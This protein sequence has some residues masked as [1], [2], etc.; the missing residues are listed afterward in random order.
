MIDFEES[1]EEDIRAHGIHLS[2]GY[3]CNICNFASINIKIAREH[4]LQPIRGVDAKVGDVFFYRQDEFVIIG[5]VPKIHFDH[6]RRYDIF[7]VPQRKPFSFLYEYND[8]LLKPEL[9][10]EIRDK[11][12]KKLLEILHKP[13]SFNQSEKQLPGDYMKTRYARFNDF[14]RGKFS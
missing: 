1:T 8:F 6:L 10:S 7:V 14:S 3:I 9:L 12:F 13:Y 2:I 4:S 5:N 11:E